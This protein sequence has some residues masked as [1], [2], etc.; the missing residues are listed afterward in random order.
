[1]R[2]RSSLSFTLPLLAGAV[3]LH[4]QAQAQLFGDPREP[5]VE[6]FEDSI[7]IE[8]ARFFAG[9]ADFYRTLPEQFPEIEIPLGLEVIGSM[10]RRD[11]QQ[12]LFR[13]Q[14]GAEESERALAQAFVNQ[15]WSVLRGETGGELPGPGEAL[16]LCHD[17]QGQ[18]WLNGEEGVENRVYLRRAQADSPDFSCT[19]RENLFSF[20]E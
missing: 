20:D 12:V 3:F 15:G 5:E 14:L 17:Q 7:P 10:D 6:R 18:V 11:R 2:I 4:P 16:S 13:S 8:L 19:G 1:M 9:G